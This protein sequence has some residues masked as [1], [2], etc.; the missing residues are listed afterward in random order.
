LNVRG[1]KVVIECEMGFFKERG[2]IMTK[3]E[4]KMKQLVFIALYCVSHKEEA[5]LVT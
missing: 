1:G 5:S 2:K 4:E 3:A